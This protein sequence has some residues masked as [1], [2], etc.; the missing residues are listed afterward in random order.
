LCILSSG[1][2]ASI[3]LF[4]GENV[5]LREGLVC[6]N[7]GLSNRLRL[8]YKA[9]EEFCDGPSGMSGRKIYVAERLTAF[10]HRLLNGYLT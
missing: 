8:L 1:D 7:C 4:L 6:K 5:N 9:I 2:K 10:Y 3:G